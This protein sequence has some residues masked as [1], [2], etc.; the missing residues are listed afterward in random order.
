MP[1]GRGRLALAIVLAGV[2]LFAAIAGFASPN[3]FRVQ[4]S[5]WL[6]TIFVVV[7][8][9]LLELVARL[10]PVEER[11]KFGYLQV[12]IGADG[13]IST[14]KSVVA[15]WTLVFA[16]ALVQ[17]TGMTVFTGL[18]AQE[19]FGGDWNSFLLL[20]GG[21]FASAVA[22]KGITVAQVSSDPTA[23]SGTL[24][25]GATA[26]PTTVQTT[27]TPSAADLVTDDGGTTSLPDTQYVVFS[28]VAILYFVGAFIHNIF[29]FAYGAAESN[30][31]LPDIPPALL[32]LTSLS[33][34]TYVGHKAVR[35]QGLRVVTMLPNPVVHGGSLIIA[36]VN[37]PA[38]ATVD[39]TSVTYRSADG[40]E[41]TRA[42]GSVV[43][44]KVSVAAPDAAGIYQVTVVSSN[45]VT[46]P[47]PLTVT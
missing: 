25:A 46:T 11:K 16:M 23:K 22:A 21:P 42:P 4:A 27:Q 6:V 37:L 28:L 15:L 1:Q 47:Q 9:G 24:A 43:N 32:G 45:F 13:R 14:S 19:A 12:I 17:L 5:M 7:I 40:T 8:L 31:T 33:A 30:V 44:G 39:N 10:D 35:D 29:R 2:P 36:L 26:V 41:T 18:S 20:L 3:W 34:L 38:T